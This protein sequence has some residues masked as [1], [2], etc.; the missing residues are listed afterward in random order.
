MLWR[1]SQMGIAEEWLKFA[2]KPRQPEGDDRWN[3]FLSY[4]SVNRAWVLNLYDVLHELGHAVFLD[5]V[6]LKAGDP[7]TRSLQDALRTSQAGVLI[8]STAT[9]DSEW[10]ERE[11]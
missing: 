3:L 10:V 8:W 5:Q 9:A 11:Y 2:P 1:S 6:A 4:R 7:L